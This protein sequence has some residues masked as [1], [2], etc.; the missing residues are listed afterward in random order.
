MAGSR[1]PENMKTFLK[2]YFPEISIAIA[3]ILAYLPSFFWMWDRWFAKD[4]YY[5]HGILIPFV[6]GYLIWLK[7]KE[8]ARIP[9]R[10]SPW[11]MW[12]IASGIIVHAVSSL[13]RVYFS[14]L[15]SLLLV[16][17]GII[18]CLYGSK[19]LK[20][21]IFPVLFLFF[22]MPLPLVAVVYISFKM[23]LF[24]AGIARSVLQ[25]MGFAAI[26]EGSIIKMPHASV[27]IDD[28]CSGLRSLISLTALA[29]VFVYWMKGSAV[30][31]VFIALSALPIAVATNVCRIVF[32]SFA[33]E[34]WGPQYATGFIHDLSG[35]F[36]FA[37]AFAMLYVLVKLIDSPS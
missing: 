33:S 37:L 13:F 26:R 25:N 3:T 11:G 34:V 27:I 28:V 8:L 23:K 32:L 22:M 35:F 15:F 21:I 7:K 30:K 2:K 29:S 19:I 6:S 12:F 4:S 31:K 14:S 20:K 16:I 10:Y 5:S 24:A 18:L 36:V 1:N 9:R 17:V